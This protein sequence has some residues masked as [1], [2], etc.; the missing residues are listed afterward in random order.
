MTADNP[1]NPDLDL[2]AIASRFARSGRAQIADILRGEVAEAVAAELEAQ[3]PWRFSIREGE[4]DAVYTH[5]A[6]E[7]LALGDRRRILAQANRQASDGF[8]YMFDYFG[9]VSGVSGDGAPAALSALTR[10]IRSEE[11]ARFLRDVTGIGDIATADAQATRYRAGQYLSRHDDLSN[12]LRRVAYV[13]GFTRAWRADWGGLLVF[14]DPRDDVE[15]AWLPRFN[16]L[17]VFK[18][19][20]VH[21]VSF[22]TPS[23][24]AYR[25]SITGWALAPQS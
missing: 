10:F 7:A 24:A 17:N 16:T 20:Q 18:V 1:I 21:S 22:V 12:P 13:M 15:E 25:H 14:H 4:R 8:Q 5:A 3:V 2:A 23:A 6:W 19:P 11:F 9:L